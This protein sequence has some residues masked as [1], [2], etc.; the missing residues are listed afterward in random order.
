LI[1]TCLASAWHSR[2]FCVH[3]PLQPHFRSKVLWGQSCFA[4]CCFPS[5][6]STAT[7]FLL[8]KPSTCQYIMIAAAL[9]AL[10]L[11]GRPFLL[12]AGAARGGIREADSPCLLRTVE[13]AFEFF[14]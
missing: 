9:L 7:F 2:Y 8:E 4:K 3:L 12:F 10:H 14:A 5:L 13:A 11:P 6:C 1:F